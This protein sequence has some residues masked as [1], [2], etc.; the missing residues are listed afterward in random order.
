[1]IGKSISH[2]KILEKLGEGGMG[3]VY[4]A[5]D[6][7]LK[8]TVALKFLPPGSTRDP[9]A[10]ERFV[11]EA[12]AASALEHPNICNIHEIDET[13]DGQLFIAMA[14]YEGESL[15]EKIARGPLKLDEA[16]DIAA[17]V[18]L[19]LSKAHENGIVHRDIKPANIL[20]TED[21]SAKIV[22]FGLAKLLGEADLTAPGKT[23]GTVKYMAPEQTRGE[24]VDHRTDIWALGIVVYE[25]ASGR[26]PFRGE[27]SQA[28][29]RA[30]L[31]E[32]PEPLVTAAS[33]VPRELERIV[34]R[35]VAKNADDRY[36][37]AAEI[38]VDL[39]MLMDGTNSAPPTRIVDGAK[40][41]ASIAV[42][43]F[44]NMSTDPNQE[45]FCD[46][47]TE[48]VINALAQLE[49]LRVVAR[50]SA[51]AF[52]GEKVDLRDVGRK[53]NV[54]T[55]LEGSVRKS[56]K[57]LRIAA[58]LI[59]VADGY[60]LWSETY[61]R[62]ME[63]VFAIQDD[64][65]L[66]IVDTLKVRLL[67]DDR[68]GFAGRRTDD[69]EAY[70]LYLKGRFYWNERGPS[71]VRNAQT[72]FRRAIERDTGFA[73]A[74]AGLA[75]TYSV[76]EN[77]NMCTRDEAEQTLREA[78]AAALKAIELD[79]LAEAHASLGWTKM[80]LHRDWQGAE[81]EFARAIELNPSYAT[82]RHWYSVCLRVMGREDEALQ[83][84]KQAQELDPLSPIVGTHVGEM[85][86]AVGKLD[87][88]IDQLKKT[89]EMHPMF[90][91]ALAEL[92][93]VYLKKGMKEKARA[94]IED[95]LSV[96][97]GEIWRVGIAYIL[98][99]TDEQDRAREEL[100]ELERSSVGSRMPQTI[101]AAVHGALG[102]SDRAF[103][104][105]EEVCRSRSSDVIN[106]LTESLLDGLR[107]DPRFAALRRKVGLEA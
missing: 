56:G 62:E 85:L 93:K 45:Y 24:P 11:R 76:L 26:P 44:T 18:A 64:I 72:C 73:Q 37:N 29:I 81:G 39:K 69:I 13:E 59:N 49:D 83:M 48:E 103:E 91:L 92:A 96:P 104:L 88:A 79:D 3:V 66:A 75:D 47:I 55:V 58:Q 99:V 107:A 42:L 10:K 82:A 65:S 33:G 54:G 32:E 14:C 90:G 106:L 21:G 87:E 27:H 89:L 20:I 53:L 61:D 23:L 74:Y 15:R 1:M 63:D 94:S 36:Q 46:G 43:P 8:R 19:G 16:V 25:M 67:G 38:L 97:G 98:A 70:N 68:T 6:T 101:M 7:K 34:V 35:A 2:Y 31:E 41:R 50:T 105:L 100:R 84:L 71:S 78:E 12:Q 102:D 17:Q 51:F 86:H 52:K 9:E 22:D 28:V 77:W 57:R 60:H 5:E 30:I 4:K 80:A 95:A 40:T